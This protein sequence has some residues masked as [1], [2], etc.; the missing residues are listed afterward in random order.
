MLEVVVV[1]G[2]HSVLWEALDETSEAIAD[3]LER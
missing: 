2:G 3:F 1:P